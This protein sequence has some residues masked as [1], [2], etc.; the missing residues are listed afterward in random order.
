MELRMHT[1]TDKQVAHSQHLSP[2][3]IKEI[4]GV[5]QHELDRELSI[6][7]SHK[8]SMKDTDDGSNSY[9]GGSSPDGV[10][11]D[12]IT[13]ASSRLSV[14]SDTVNSLETRLTEIANGT[15]TG[16]CDTCHK[17]IEFERL[18][19]QPG[20]RRHQLCKRNAGRQIQN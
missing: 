9:S 5:A 7:D 16:I 17:P 1:P 10:L 12:E 19:A 6:I 11:S 2:I 8:K 4:R 18:L 13:T 3:Q 15:F 14:V 20:T